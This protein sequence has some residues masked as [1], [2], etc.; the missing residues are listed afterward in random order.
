M[1]NGSQDIGVVDA[2]LA[3]HLQAAAGSLDHLCVE[4]L[5]SSTHLSR[6][7]IDKRYVV[8]LA[9]EP[10]GKLKTDIAC[11]NDEN[12]HQE[13]EAQDA[14]LTLLRPP[15]ALT[16]VMVE[17]LLANAQRD[18]RHFEQVVVAQVLDG[19]VKRQIVRDVQHV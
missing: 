17:N 14:R 2:S 4:L 13:W 16:D 6:I 8:L 12:P 19:V 5:G 1:G 9:R 11:A 15:R 7:G 3:Q 18:R 10:P